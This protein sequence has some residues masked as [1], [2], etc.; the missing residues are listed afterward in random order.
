[1]Q[2]ESG[3]TGE[4]KVRTLLLFLMVAVFSA[5][6][7]YD[8][9]VGYPRSNYN[10]HL[11]QLTKEERESVGELPVYPTVNKAKWESGVKAVKEASASQRRSVLEALFEAKPS[12]ENA[13]A[14]YYFGPAY[15][16]K[17]SLRDGF[18]GDP[19]IGSPATKSETSIEWQL[20][21]GA[22]LAVVS[23]YLLWFVLRVVR[24]HL[25]LDDT[26]LTYSGRGPIRWDQMKQLDISRFADKGWV[27][28]L[29]DDNGA[30]GRVR[31]DEY[32]LARFDDII[33][34]ICER[35]GFENPLPVD[36]PDPEPKQA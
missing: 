18:P 36:A 6:F 9:W 17:V 33:D 16:V 30:E 12:Y 15:R 2:I 20:Y 5:W 8:G 23:V 27:D 22:V 35:K 7:A 32:H 34:E 21:L 1:M 19:M 25:V 29:Y 10:E 28:L 31:L 13:E 4:R 14:M 26:G 24:T 3:P 11:G